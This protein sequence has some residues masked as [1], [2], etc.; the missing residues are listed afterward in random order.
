[1]LPDET[2]AI[3]D[4]H[5]DGDFRI[6]P[7]AE[8]KTSAAQIEAIGRKYGVVYPQELV[9]HICGRFP[10]LYVEVKE[11]IWPRPKPYEV[12]AFWSFLYALHTFTS[13]PESD[14]W[15]RLD[16]AADSFQKG[17]GL[18]AAPVLKVVG[19]ADLYCIAADGRLVRFI[20][21]ENN[22]EP[23]ALNFWQL[24]DREIAELHARKVQKKNGG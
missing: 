6:F 10:G 12:G 4:R 14:D 7:M 3:L 15:M 2:E 21:D 5:L 17:T 22:L 19:D 24:L 18:V 16:H 11:E 23:V 8:T 13:A 1:M 9:A 20:H